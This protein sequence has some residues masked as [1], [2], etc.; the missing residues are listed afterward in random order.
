MAGE[1]FFNMNNSRRDYV[2]GNLFRLL[3]AALANGNDIDAFCKRK[4]DQRQVLTL[5]YEQKT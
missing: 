1:G 4:T 3:G 2:G 5:G